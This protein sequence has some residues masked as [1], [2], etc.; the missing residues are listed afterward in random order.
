M[1]GLLRR[2]R[3]VG[4]SH[5]ASVPRPKTEPLWS[6]PKNTDTRPRRRSRCWLWFSIND[7]F[8]VRK[9]HANLSPSIRRFAA[10]TAALGG[11]CRCPLGLALPLASSAATLRRWGHSQLCFRFNLY[12]DFLLG[13]MCGQDKTYWLASTAAVYLPFPTPH[14]P[15]SSSLSSSSWWG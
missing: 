6:S 13:V 11:A 5:G 4:S 2:R 15:S 14:H 3:R 12:V 1:L 9:L 7:L 8:Y 10:P